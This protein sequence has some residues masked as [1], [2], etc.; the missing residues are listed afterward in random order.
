MKLGFWRK[1]A[2][3]N[4]T[5]GSVTYDQMDDTW[6]RIYAGGSLIGAYYCMKE[7][8]KGIDAFD[9]ANTMVFATSIVTGAPA[10]CLSRVAVSA[11]SPITG[12]IGDSQAGGYWAAE[13]KFAGLDAVVVTGKAASPSYLWIHDGIVEIC[14]A[15]KLKGCNTGETEEFIRAETGQAKAHI[16]A[17]GPAGENKVLYSCIVNGR[18]HVNG[19]SGMG[20]VMGSKNLKA[21]AVFG[22]KSNLEFYN[23]K[24]LIDLAKL[25][26]ERVKTTPSPLMFSMFGTSIL[27][28]SMTEAGALPTKNYSESYFDSWKNISHEKLHEEL[29]KKSNSCYACPIRC[30]RVVESEKPYKIDPSYGGPEYE[31]L[32]SFGSYLMIDDINVIAKAN[33]LCNKYSLDTISCG[34]SIAFAMECYEKGLITPEMSDGLEITFGNKDV[35]LPLIEKI[36]HREGIGNILADGPRKAAEIIGQGSEQFA[37]QVKGNPLPAHMPRLLNGIALSYAVN[38]YGADHL[39]GGHDAGFMPNAEGELAEGLKEFGVYE[40][41]APYDPSLNKARAVYFTQMFHSMMDSMCLCLFGFGPEGSALYSPDDLIKIISAATGWKMSFWELL[42]IGE[43]KLALQRQFNKREG[44]SA[45][46]DTLPERLFTPFEKGPLTGLAIQKEAFQTMKNDYYQMAGLS[47]V[48]G[49]PL[50]GKLKELRLE[51]TIE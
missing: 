12:G 37:M 39:V 4:L 7:I 5:D 25:A 27:V 47:E 40:A 16:M 18:H 28:Q 14:V 17:I 44:L 2:K 38:P 9:S 13:L 31:T 45:K 32:A 6:Y 26:S 36:A 30:K 46:D 49:M 19:R 51:W 1:I 23:K 42:K 29:C 41:M 3:V 33:E 20:A 11:K 22:K 24:D 10:A 35:L 48:D 8:P 50:L 15:D 43:R 21:L 34:G